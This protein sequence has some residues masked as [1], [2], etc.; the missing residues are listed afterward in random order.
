MPLDANAAEIL[1]LTR[2]HESSTL[3][4]F[5]LTEQPPLFVRGEGAM[6]I[7]D[8]GQRVTDLVC[9]SC[10]SN[11]GH[12][13][14]RQNAALKRQIDTGILHTGTRLPNPA[15]AE[16]YAELSTLFPD[17]MNAIHLMTSGS[18][19]VESAI[20]AAQYATG[21]RQVISF[22]GAFHG[23]TLGA[24]SVSSVRSA[25]APFLPLDPGVTFFPYPYGLR[26][27]FP[28]APENLSEFCLEYLRRSLKNPSSGLDA[29]SCLLV[30]A[31]QGVGGV[32]VPPV[33]FLA[34]LRAICDEFDLIMIVDEIWNGFGRSGN[35]F[36]Y[37][38]EAIKPD[39][40]TIA[41]G[42]TS[43]LPMSAVIGPSDLLQQWPAGLH[44]GTFQGNPLTCA[45]A[46]ETIR[47]M[48]DEAVVENVQNVIAP[49]FAALLGPLI[50]HAHVAQLRVNGGHAALELVD[51]D[52]GMTP[53]PQAVK[54]VQRRCLARGVLTYGGGIYGNC[55][56]FM[57]PLIIER[58]L[59]RD[60]LRIVVEEV[61][62]LARVP[63]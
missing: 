42:L 20:K 9:G 15:R 59:L 55:L 41:K 18:E 16:L 19:A 28:C 50:E 12:G 40:V 6:L 58:D 5:A 36:A 31:V 13:H 26:P 37:Q 22:Q 34:G 62:A 8:A 21:R 47:I 52:D 27:P 53:D 24:L 1:D 3:N 17:D 32:I 48:R 38:A 7:T 63:A 25:R 33:G 57:P 61:G 30:E 51:A 49:T 10:V 60:A 14:P 44:T 45:V 43:T 29:P 23:R 2:Q 35:W 39:L 4:T 46:A 11:L 56:M 54:T